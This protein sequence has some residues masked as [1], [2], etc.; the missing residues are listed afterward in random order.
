[1]GSDSMN[2]NR[3]KKTKMLLVAFRKLLRAVKSQATTLTAWG[4]KANCCCHYRILRAVT[5]R[6]TEAHGHHHSCQGL[7]APSAPMLPHP[8]AMRVDTPAMEFA[9]HH[10][11]HA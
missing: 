5:A 2:H 6:W 11:D 7:G 1:M 3:Q 9:F 8:A 4:T 10:Q